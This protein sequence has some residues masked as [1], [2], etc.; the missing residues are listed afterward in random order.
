M[1]NA[2][3]DLAY[4]GRGIVIGMTGKGDLFVAYFVT[5]RSPSSQARR[6]GRDGK[7][8]FTEPT[9]HA[10]LAKGNPDLLIYNAVLWNEKPGVVAVSNGKQTDTVFSYGVCSTGPDV[11]LKDATRQWNYEP[12]KP[13]FTPRISG[14][15]L[16]VEN[17]LIAAQ[18]GIIS[19]GAD[20][21]AVR[22]MFDLTNAINACRD[23]GFAYLLTTYKGGS[24][25]PLLPFEGN[26]QKLSIEG[27]S[28]G[29]ICEEV[30]GMLDD[31]LRVGVAALCVPSKYGDYKPAVINYHE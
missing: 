20:G 22:R 17:D 5:G 26:P 15:V 10:V 4:P 27:I 24:E 28:A 29:E 14:L 25:S 23:V 16:L 9:D 31:R 8:V 18:L 21:Q 11:D 12:D 1:K 7:M 13:N 3:E 2:L 30:G 19:R 6:F